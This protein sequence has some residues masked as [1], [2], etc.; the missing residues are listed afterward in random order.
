MAVLV[1]VD[2]VQRI[3]PI[4]TTTAKALM[5]SRGTALVKL[6]PSSTAVAPSFT[7]TYANILSA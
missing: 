6:L 5:E 7:A 3:S 1:A 4:T 2:N